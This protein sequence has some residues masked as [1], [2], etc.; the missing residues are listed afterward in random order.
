MAANVQFLYPSAS[1]SFDR[2]PLEE[3]EVLGVKLQKNVQE[4]NRSEAEMW[5]KCRGCGNLSDLTL[6]LR[7]FLSDAVAFLIR[8]A[9]KNLF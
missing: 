2:I 3:S 6:D 8:T 1:N 4:L 5:L 9:E 7:L